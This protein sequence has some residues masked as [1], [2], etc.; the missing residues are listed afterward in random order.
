MGPFQTGITGSAGM[1]ARPNDSAQVIQCAMATRVAPCG[2]NLMVDP[3]MSLGSASS[4]GGC[5]ASG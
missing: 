4:P 5:G 2:A 1:G 3:A